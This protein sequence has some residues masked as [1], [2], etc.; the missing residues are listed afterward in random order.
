MTRQTDDT[1][2]PTTGEQP[3]YAHL[4]SG[5]KRTPRAVELS[6]HTGPTAGGEHA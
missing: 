3:A 5:R 6:L 2:G 4:D 1:D